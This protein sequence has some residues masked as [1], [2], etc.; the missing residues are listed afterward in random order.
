MFT[1]L[2]CSFRIELILFNNLTSKPLPNQKLLINNK[3]EPET[4]TSMVT[5]QAILIT[6]EPVITPQALRKS[7]HFGTVERK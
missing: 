2:T 6:S 5:F 7:A 3:K 4:L 1:L